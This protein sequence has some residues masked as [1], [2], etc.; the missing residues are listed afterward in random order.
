MEL[1]QLKYFLTLA[2]TGNMTS[3]ARAHFITQQALSKSIRKLEEELGAVL[4]ERTPQ[5]VRLTEYG[6]CLLPYAKRM[7]HSADAASQA[8]ADLKNASQFAIHMGY[9]LGSFHSHGV[10]PPSLIEEWEAG[11]TGAIVFQQEYPPD[12]LVRLLLEE[13]LDLACTIDPQDMDLEGLTTVTLA[14]EPLCLHLS[15]EL[16]HGRESLSM[17]ELEQ[18]PILTWKIGLNPG[19]HFEQLCREANFQPKILYINA[20][21]GQ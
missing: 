1:K 13:E 5:G 20:Y 18:I 12:V 21:F 7:L 9:V 3:A 8:I 11:Q 19:E 4:F 2:K 10:V 14:E 6:K 16:L 15:E 17:Q